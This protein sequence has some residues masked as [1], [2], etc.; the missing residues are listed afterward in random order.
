MKLIMVVFLEKGIRLCV[1][2]AKKVSIL[3]ENLLVH[4][5]GMSTAA[6]IYA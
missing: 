1:L 4:G 6:Q 5:W 2:K 3:R